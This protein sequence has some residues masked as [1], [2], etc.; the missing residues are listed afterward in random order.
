MFQLLKSEL[1]LGLSFGVNFGIKTKIEI[2][3]EKKL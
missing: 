2:F 3:G 1:K